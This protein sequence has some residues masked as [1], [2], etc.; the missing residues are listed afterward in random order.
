MSTAPAPEKQAEQRMHAADESAESA[1]LS[2]STALASPLDLLLADAANGPLR[3]FMPGMS[4]V[5]FTA[6]LARRPRVLAKRTAGLAYEL[7]RV[8]P[9]PLAA[10]TG[11]E[12]PPVQRGGL[13]QEPGLQAHPAGLP[14]RRRGRSRPGRRRR[15]R[16][17]RRPADAL[18]RRQPRRGGRAEQQPVPQPQGDQ[19]DARHRRR[20]PG[21]GRPALR[22]GL[23]HRA[24]GA[25]DG[26]GRRVR[27]GPRHRGD[28]RR[29]RAAH[30]RLRADPVHAADPQGPL[31][32]AADRAADD[33]QVLRDRPRRAALPGGV[34]RAERP[35]GVLH[36]LAQPRR[37]ARRLGA[38]HLRPGDPRG[39]EG[40]RGDHQ[41]G[42]HGDLR[43]LL[44]RHDR[45]DGDGPPRRRSASRTASRRTAWR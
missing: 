25:L 18:H 43:H 33:Q 29:R 15:A 24:A 32:A 22:Q 1:E 34:P 9:G 27:G 7:T 36:L 16:L 6:G 39:D 23:R 28:A 38:G 4:G 13:G 41:A 44:R 10:R 17:G 20:Q 37:A 19:A 8:G 31:R 3:R 26:R 42:Q 30:R 2:A 40:L 11:R 45:L 21:R 35:A 5:K 14:R 12:G